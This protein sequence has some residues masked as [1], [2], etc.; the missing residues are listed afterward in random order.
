MTTDFDQLR[1]LLRRRS[2]DARV[3]DL[4]GGDPAIIERNEYY[5]SVE[6]KDAGVDLVLQESPWVLPPSEF[7]D[8]KQLYVAGFHFHRAGHEGYAQYQGGFPGGTAFDDSELDIRRKLGQPLK[9][10]GGGTI[11][12]LKKPVPRWLGY[13]LGDAM[14]HFQLDKSGKVEMVTLEVEN[15]GRS[16]TTR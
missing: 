9:T 8:P 13:S 10:G 7:T 12:V 4:I 15:P 2:D 3:M 5:G 6:F 16:G 14:I 11:P 1:S